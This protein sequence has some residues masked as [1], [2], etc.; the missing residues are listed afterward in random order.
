LG[1]IT[2]ALQK[3]RLFNEH[4]TRSLK[5]SATV[6]ISVLSVLDKVL[7]V[8][9]AN[10]KPNSRPSGRHHED[11]SDDRN[12]NNIASSA[13]LNSWTESMQK[14]RGGNAYMPSEDEYAFNANQDISSVKGLLNNSSQERLN[15]WTESAQR[16]QRSG[17]MAP[18]SKNTQQEIAY[19]ENYVHQVR[20]L[21]SNSSVDRMETWTDSMKHQQA[22]SPKK[23]QSKRYSHN[24]HVLKFV[25]I[26]LISLLVSIFPSNTLVR[27]PEKEVVAMKKSMKKKTLKT[28][29]K[30]LKTMRQKPLL[31]QRQQKQPQ[32]IHNRQVWA[33]VVR[34]EVVQR[35]FPSQREERPMSLRVLRPKGLPFSLL[36]SC[37]LAQ[38][39]TIFFSNF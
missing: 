33:K 34:E 11:A 29:M 25:I 39:F 4:Q 30:I 31:H 2:I 17:K 21:R 1:L 9:M 27:A 7:V 35:A 6:T 23:H 10:R 13:Q 28:T 12:L 19:D 32:S 36:F 20:D 18:Q 16:D 24:I 14:Q 38:I 22:V 5:L 8:K 37:F 3:I 26:L 15:T